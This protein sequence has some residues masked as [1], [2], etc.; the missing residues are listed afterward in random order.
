MKTFLKKLEKKTNLSTNKQKFENELAQKQQEL[1][2]LT[3]KLSDKE[4]KIEEKKQKVEENTD[5]KYELL[6]NLNT[7]DANYENLEKRKKQ[8]QNEI[9]STISELDLERGNKQEL[10]KG[11]Y[12]LENKRFLELY[13]IKRNDMN[14]YDLVIDTSNITPIKR[15]CWSK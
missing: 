9:A 6:G 4:L 11:F 12:E 2:E 14:N 10:S 7:L 1:D 15:P 3:K 5:K 13:G 8:L